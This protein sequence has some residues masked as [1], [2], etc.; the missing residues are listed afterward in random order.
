M[1]VCV[2]YKMST[3]ESPSDSHKR[4]GDV[5]PHLKDI[6]IHAEL[7]NPLSNVAITLHETQN[8][9]NADRPYQLIFKERSVT[10]SVNVREFKVDVH[11][12][13]RQQPE[14][15]VSIV[16]TF[17]VITNPA[18]ALTILE[19]SSSMYMLRDPGVGPQYT[20]GLQVRYFYNIHDALKR[21]N[22]Q[23]RANDARERSEKAMAEYNDHI[24]RRLEDA[25]ERLSN[26]SYIQ[27]GYFPLPM[28]YM[29]WDEVS[30]PREMERDVRFTQAEN[31]KIEEMKR[32]EKLEVEALAEHQRWK[33]E[34]ER[35]DAIASVPLTP[36][37]LT[38]K[39]IPYK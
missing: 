29:E 27:G 25:L 15:H 10:Q 38:H 6:T 23:K 31:L 17:D 5:Y 18:N 32:S 12:K 19:E 20:Y 21:G 28:D 35:L 8:S 34:Y 11:S 3:F 7:T 36:V 1:H 39:L 30:M 26:P 24:P 14:Q 33:S 4:L 22:A 2:F 9:Q 16:R 13:H 37:T